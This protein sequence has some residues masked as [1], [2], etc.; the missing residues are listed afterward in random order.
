MSVTTDF[1]PSKEELRGVIYGTILY[2]SLYLLFFVQFQS[3]SK[4]Y[5]YYYKYKNQIVKNK[6]D[7]GSLSKKDDDHIT[8]TNST[9]TTTTTTIPSFRNVK[10]YN[11]TDLIA[12]NGDRTVGNFL[13]QSIV[14]LPLLWI[15][16]LF[17]DPNQ[18]FM[19]CCMYT[20]IRAF[21]P[22]VFYT[23]YMFLITIPGYAIIIY[24]AYNILTGL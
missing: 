23:K 11:T 17:I 6:K 14:F 15:H 12:L 13:E 3:Y 5:I 18:S 4:F 16:A 8:N 19:I 1:P 22:F 2:L 10:Y 20:T 7:K 9:T 24:L 21:Y